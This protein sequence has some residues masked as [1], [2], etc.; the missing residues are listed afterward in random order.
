MT[1]NW[2]PGLPVRQSVTVGMV[3]SNKPEFG[4][5]VNGVGKDTSPLQ[6]R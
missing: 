4:V 5:K 3:S 6:R 1:D 2:S